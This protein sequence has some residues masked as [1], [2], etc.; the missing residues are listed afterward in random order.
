MLIRGDKDQ[1]LPIEHSE[2]LEA[3]LRV[4]N[5]PVKLVRVIG[6]DHAIQAKPEL[7]DVTPEMVR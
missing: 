1:L 3:A 2:K 5:A 7:P 6:A 4:A